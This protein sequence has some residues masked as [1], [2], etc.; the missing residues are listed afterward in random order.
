MNRQKQKFRQK[1]LIGNK[2]LRHK[3]L[4]YV[5]QNRVEDPITCKKQYT[6]IFSYF[7]IE[8]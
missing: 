5:V 7:Y 4:F 8:R 6:R 1:G 3:I 2:T